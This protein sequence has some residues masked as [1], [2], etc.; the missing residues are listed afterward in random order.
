MMIVDV[1]L[2]VSS[3]DAGFISKVVV[4][5]S[6]GKEDNVCVDVVVKYMVWKILKNVAVFIEHM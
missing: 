2:F 5:D 4:P 3:V 6:E 1:F